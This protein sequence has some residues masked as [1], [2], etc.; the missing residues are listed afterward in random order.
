MKKSMLVILFA[1]AI[2]SCNNN[3]K[4]EPKFEFPKYSVSEEN[5]INNIKEVDSANVQIQ[6]SAKSNLISSSSVNKLL[7]E[8]YFNNEKNLDESFM[9]KQFEEIKQ[10]AKKEILNFNEYDVLELKIFKNNTEV[11]TYEEVIES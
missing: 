4:S 7:V 1:F 6:F 11:K 10:K 2:V 8:I 9:K 5:F 3:I